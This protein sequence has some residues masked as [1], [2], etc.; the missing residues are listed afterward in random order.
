MEEALENDL[1]CEFK[2]AV[3]AVSKR[4]A[5]EVAIDWWRGVSP[6]SSHRRNR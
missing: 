3:D 5:R 4:V 1:V 6:E 2:E